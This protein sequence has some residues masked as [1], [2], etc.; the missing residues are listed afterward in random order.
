MICVRSKMLNVSPKTS[1]S[2]EGDNKMSK[3]EYIGLVSSIMSIWYITRI[4]HY[5]EETVIHV[6]AFQIQ[7]KVEM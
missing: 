4:F 6:Y 5:K 3:Y 1:P 2:L 7:I